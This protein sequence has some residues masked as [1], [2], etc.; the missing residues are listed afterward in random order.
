MGI[1]HDKPALQYSSGFVIDGWVKK[2]G[3]NYI[4]DIGKLVG[5]QLKLEE[6]QRNRTVDVY[7]PFARSLEWQINLQVPDGY[8]LEGIEKL[9][10]ST[11][12]ASAAFI[13]KATLEG[14]KL[15]L[16]VSK[17]YKNA[18]EPAANWPN[19]VA[20]IDAAQNFTNAKLLLK[21][22]G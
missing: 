5:S 19:L 4:V 13:S 12:N 17:S 8:T 18:F 11:D 7:M 20:M 16:R 15:I 3:N 6:K 1:R 2:A 14:N 21:K 9:N 10:G 22:K